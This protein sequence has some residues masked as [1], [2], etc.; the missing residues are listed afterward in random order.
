MPVTLRA[1]C[2]V[3]AVCLCATPARAQTYPTAIVLEAWASGAPAPQ[4]T[5]RADVAGRC[6]VTDLSTVAHAIVVD[7][8]FQGGQACWWPLM[9]LPDGVYIISA[10]YEGTIDGAPFVSSRTDSAIFVISA[11]PPPPPPPPTGCPYQGR[12]YATTAM[13][14]FSTNKGHL[15]QDKAALVAAGFLITS[16]TTRT[17]VA[18]CER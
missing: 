5:V 6:G 3:L 7:D 17:I 4:A 10:T 18:V 8:P 9:P 13:Q 16:A 12:T 1:L 11:P 15:D 2:V 14:S